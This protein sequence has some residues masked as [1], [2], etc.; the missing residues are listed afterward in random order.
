[1]LEPRKGLLNQARDFPKN[2]PMLIIID[3]KIKSRLHVK[4]EHAYLLQ[5][6]D[7]LSFALRGMVFSFKRESQNEESPR[8]GQAEGLFVAR[9]TTYLLHLISASMTAKTFLRSSGDSF[10]ICS[11]SREARRG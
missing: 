3:G 1:M 11:E 10:S 5:K 8:P 9:N 4:Q 7:K 2:G 6:G